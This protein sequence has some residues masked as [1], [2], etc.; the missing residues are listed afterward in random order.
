MITPDG[1]HILFNDGREIAYRSLTD[2]TTITVATVAAVG[3]EQGVSASRMSPDGKWIAY[4]SIESG[5]FQV[6]VRPFPG[7]NARYQISV[8]GGQSPVWSRDSR[9]IVYSAA[10]RALIAATIATSPTFS[11]AKRDTLFASQHEYAT[12]HANYDLA[13][14][15]KQLLLVYGNPNGYWMVV[16]HW[17]AELRKRIA[18]R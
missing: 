16:R 18:A 15:G 1:K 14:D 4:H 17:D 3:S 8:E 13:P 9:R 5:K 6:Y 10:G 7:L 11:V 12:A 2:T